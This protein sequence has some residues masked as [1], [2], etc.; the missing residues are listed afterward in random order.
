ME[1][2]LIISQTI[3]YFTI[4]IVVITLGV[5]ATVVTYHLIKI[6]KALEEMSRNIHNASSDAIE[7]IKDLIERLSILPILSFFLKKSRSKKTQR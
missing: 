4:S 1:N 7:R 6:T 3:F 5:L 2:A